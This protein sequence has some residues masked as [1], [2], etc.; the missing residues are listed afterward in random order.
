MA[1][2]LNW[3]PLA[4]GRPAMV[5]H[6]PSTML[7]FLRTL[8]ARS[9]LSD[10][11]REAILRLPFVPVQVKPNRDFVRHDQ[12]V[13][14]SCFV[15]D[16]VVGSFKQ[17]RD[18]N[19]QIVAVFINGD[20]VDLHSA[21]APRALS[22]LQALTTTTILQVPHPALLQVAREFPNVAEAFWRHCVID[23][24]ILMEWVINVG[25]RDAQKRMA[26]FFCELAT[27]SARGTPE[28]GMLI[29][30]PITQFQ[31]SDILSL[32]AV[33]VNRTLQAL[34]QAR[35]LETVDRS[36]QR[37]V[38]WDRLALAGDFD[39]AYLQLGGDTPILDAA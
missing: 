1:E 25:R 18:G 39:P 26:H 8:E 16:G 23:A 13:T 36:F 15:L 33:H 27:R 9:N 4:K 29:P 21:V 5:S 12:R 19:R 6:E 32:T 3:L 28:D 35:L 37:I 24:G 2:R 34:R 38:D 11:E 14:H 7:P 17:D 20:M 10:Q 22:A 31:L 30:Y